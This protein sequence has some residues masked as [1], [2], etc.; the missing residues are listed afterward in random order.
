MRLIEARDDTFAWLQG[1]G[2]GPNLAL[3][4]GGVAEPEV[5]RLLHEAALGGARTWLMVAGGGAGEVVGL[6][7]VK[8]APQAGTVEIGYGTAPARRRRGHATAAV[9][10]LLSVLRT[11]GIARAAAETA[12]GNRV[13]ERV[14]E[15]A[16]F[17]RAGLRETPIGAM[18]LW[19]RAL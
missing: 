5:V 18:T 4:P 16:G 3:P 19:W 17:A 2:A 6:C 7:G 14:L 12:P 11:E 10:L 9:P 8:G 15:R 13:S 1:E